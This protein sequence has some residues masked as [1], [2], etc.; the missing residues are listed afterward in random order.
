[1]HQILHW[2]GALR[3][4]LYGMGI[5]LLISLLAPASPVAAAELP[6]V[7]VTVAGEFAAAPGKVAKDLSGVAC[8]PSS[9]AAARCLL[10]NDE[11]VSAQ[12][13]TL[14]GATLTPG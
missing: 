4:R 8:L 3:P 7:D 12:F 6:L 5:T 13:A 2:G 1:M 9:G 10:I 11:N 14:E